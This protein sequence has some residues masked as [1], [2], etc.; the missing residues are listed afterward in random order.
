MGISGTQF[1]YFVA[2]RAL[3]FFFQS[4]PGSAW[5]RWLDCLLGKR[6]KNILALV[7]VSKKS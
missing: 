2:F 7:C 4:F 5:F 1:L 6:S 3:F